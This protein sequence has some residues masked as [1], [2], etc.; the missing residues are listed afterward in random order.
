MRLKRGPFPPKRGEM[1]LKEA[2][3]LPEQEKRG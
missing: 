2:L 3:L 1:R